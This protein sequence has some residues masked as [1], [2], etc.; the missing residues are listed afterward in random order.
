MGAI[1]ARKCPTCGHHEVGFEDSEGHFYPLNP[2]DMVQVLRNPLSPGADDSPEYSSD[3]EEEEQG[4]NLDDFDVWVPKPL[5]G[6]GIL[7]CKYGVIFRKGLLKGD[8]QTS[9]Y[10]MGYMNK[11]YQMIEKVT[12]IPLPI[13]LDRYFVAPNLATGNP[14]EIAKAMWDEL[15]E[16]RQPA[17]L[18][19]EW[20][21]K[22]D[23]ESLKKMIHPMTMDDLKGD[24]ISDN[25]L[26]MELD[27]FGLEDFLETL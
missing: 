23:E 21:D 7:R 25:D 16:I 12:D 11:L 15:D 1:T 17:L 8:M 5:R 13:I 22:K 9:F 4:I 18:V 2:G 20:L 27:S 24:E 26:K 14:A 3:I 19:M 6:N 10:E